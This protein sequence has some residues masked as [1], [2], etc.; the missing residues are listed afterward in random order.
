MIFNF[1][2]AAQPSRPTWVVRS[3]SSFGERGRGRE[4]GREGKGRGGGGE[5]ESERER[6]SARARERERA[7]EKESERERA[8]ARARETRPSNTFLEKAFEQL[9]V[10]PIPLAVLRRLP[11]DSTLRGFVRDT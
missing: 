8:R 11:R 3:G 1:F 6:E 2:G 7:R 5:R 4:G 9:F 10:G